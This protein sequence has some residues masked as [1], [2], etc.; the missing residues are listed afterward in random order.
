MTNKLTPEPIWLSEEQLAALV[1]PRT[2]DVFKAFRNRG[3]TAVDEIQR[4]LVCPSK[5]I[6]YQV[7]KLLRVGLLTE[8]GSSKGAR[9]DRQVYEAVKGGLHMPEGY[10]GARYERLA[11]KGAA[12]I[13]RSMIRS[14]NETARQAEASPEIVDDLFINLTS[15]KL[16]GEEVTALRKGVVELFARF[17][18]K[19]SSQSRGVTIACVMTPHESRLGRGSHG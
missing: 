2:R 17:A 14:F 16:T 11:A 9:R 15:M 7:A 3:P 18:A 12:A 5:T 19:D 4:I 8:A 6:Y 13:L 10:Q 1:A